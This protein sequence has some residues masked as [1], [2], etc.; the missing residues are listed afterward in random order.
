MA[1][2][3]KREERARI[4]AK[5]S[6]IVVLNSRSLTRVTCPDKSLN[7]LVHGGGKEFKCPGK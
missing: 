6:V 5:E 7:Y 1:M 2:V 4:M 3:G